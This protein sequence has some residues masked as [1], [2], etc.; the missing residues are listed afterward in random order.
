MELL[1]SRLILEIFLE[2]MGLSEDSKSELVPSVCVKREISGREPKWMWE[3]RPQ[4]LEWTMGGGLHHLQKEETYLQKI[5]FT[6]SMEMG[7]CDLVRLERGKH[8]PMCL[9]HSYNK[10]VFSLKALIQHF[11]YL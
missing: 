1:S 11:S 3:W 4:N 7:Q 10:L 2:E 8:L 6:P 5:S 9:N